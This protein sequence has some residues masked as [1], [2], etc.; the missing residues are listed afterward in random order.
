MKSYKLP[1]LLII[2]VSIISYSNTLQNGFVWDDQKY[3]VESPFIH[4]WD[5][6]FS[7]FTNDYFNLSWQEVDG[8]RPVM[9]A[10]LIVDHAVWGLTPVGHHLSNLL[11]HTVNA[12]SFFYLLMMLLPGQKA[13]FIGAVLFAA[14]P[15]HSETV[16]AINFREDLLV[17]M[18][19][20]LSLSFFIKGIKAKKRWS[21]WTL[22]ILFYV[23]ALFSK[24]MAVTL[25][26]VVLL[27]LYLYRCK[28]ENYFQQRRYHFY[29]FIVLCVL[30]T[31]LY[32]F[33]LR[34]VMAH[35][36]ME[37]SFET[38]RSLPYRFFG[39]MVIIG[40][41]LYLFLFPF[42]LN[43]DYDFDPFYDI[44]L[45]NAIIAV[46]V[47]SLIIL[48]IYK[49]IFKKGGAAFFLAW[50][51]ITLIPVMNIIPIDNPIAE[52]Y[53]YLPSIGIISFFAIALDWLFRDADNRKIVTIMTVLAI[54]VGCFLVTAVKRNTVWKSNVVL[55]SETIN[56][57]HRKARVYHNLGNA[58]ASA[59][60]F[61][62]A[63][64]Y[65]NSAIKMDLDGRVRPRAYLVRGVIYI[66][67]GQYDKA[68]D[69][70]NMAIKLS[71]NM[72]LAYYNRGLAYALSGN[73]TLAILNFQ[74]ACDKG[75][76]EGCKSLLDISKK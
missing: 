59:G 18:F 75:C 44:D 46:S 32:I 54:A 60:D 45:K 70:L 31:F 11:I 6:I 61:D 58:Y 25:P 15:I 3:L 22:S 27:Y 14:H 12:L 7:L 49:T 16:N 24:E 74:V 20:I 34:L 48:T 42:N 4:R 33:F 51:F 30:L 17:T 37:T 19:Y 64:T 1:I 9:V 73:K 62:R 26:A 71:L 56:K 55:W 47:A 13:V 76:S 29:I 57:S 69:D 10:S 72:T 38:V 53:L 66:N 50:F 8:H 36:G 65:L 21:L 63:I 39:T 43:A 52:R 5:N 35:Q 68:I 2:S 41:Y 40:R 23:L 28:Y 67:K